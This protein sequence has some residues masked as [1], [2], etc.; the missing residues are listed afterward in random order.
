MFSL[1]ELMFLVGAGSALILLERLLPLHPGQKILRQGWKID[2]MHVFLTG[3][4]IR[5]G[6]VSAAI[7]ASVLAVSVVPEPV[8][9]AVRAQPDWLEFIEL[10]ILS[11][12]CFYIAHRLSHAVPM[13]WRFHAVHHSSEQLDWLATYRVHPV[14]QIFNSTMI[15]L[16][17]LVLGFSPL[18]LLVYALVYRI[19]SPL[20]HSNVRVD[21][22]WLGRLITTPRFHHWHHAD[23]VEAHDH[24]FGG[25]LTIFDRLFGTDYR[26]GISSLPE[27]YGIDGAIPLRYASHL[28]QPFAK[29]PAAD[30]AAA[31]VPVNMAN[32]AAAET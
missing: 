8:R 17:A 20:L 32:G 24:N 7:V 19:H 23:Q 4:V 5:L 21:L 16:P 25:Q 9:E 12:L 30:K 28:L 1:D 27:R 11:D 3:I 14:D 15:A 26:A 31:A 6:I 18:P 10:L 29:A 2:I 22:G 13:L